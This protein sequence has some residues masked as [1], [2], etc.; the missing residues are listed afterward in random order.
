MVLVVHIGM[1]GV[2]M[3]TGDAAMLVEWIFTAVA[4]GVPL[5]LLLILDRARK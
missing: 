5:A 3:L 2:E 1:N 4:V